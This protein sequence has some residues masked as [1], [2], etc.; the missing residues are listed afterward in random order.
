M[1]TTENNGLEVD[2][3]DAPNH[4]C[5]T[6]FPQ[7]VMKPDPAKIQALQD[8]LTPINQKEVQ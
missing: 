3:L 7:H 2:L 1:N 4:L 6:V 5:S 8:F